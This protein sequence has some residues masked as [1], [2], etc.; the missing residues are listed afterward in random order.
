MSNMNEGATFILLTI[1]FSNTRIIT[2]DPHEAEVM[3]SFVNLNIWVDTMMK[4]V[5]PYAQEDQVN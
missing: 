5:F 2:D 1:H 4:P 3:E